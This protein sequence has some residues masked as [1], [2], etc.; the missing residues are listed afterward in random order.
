MDKI[1]GQKIENYQVLSILGKGGM[2]IVYKA[3]DV[4]LDRHV[5]I[6]ILNAQMTDKLRFIER[7]KREAKN[8]A[9]LSHP[10]I[11]T[12]YGFI[13]Y[14]GL[15]GI[16]MEYVEGESLEKVIRRQKR[17]NL[18]DAIFIG[19]QL[20]NAIEY[21]HSKGFIHRDI[22]PSN[23]IFNKEGVAKIMDFGISKSMFDKGMTKTGSK[24][25]TVFY[26][27]PEQVRGKDVD[28]LSDIY[29]IGCTLYEMIVGEPPFY[30]DNDYDIMDGHLKQEPPKMSSKIAG[31]PDIID[32]ILRKALKKD[33]ADRYKDCDEFRVELHKLDKY[34]STVPTFNAMG[35][36]EDKKKVK[37]Y[38]II[39]FGTFI[40]VMFALT[41]F[42]YGQVKELLTGNNLE[43]FQTYSIESLFSSTD[44]D[45]SF[46]K[47]TPINLNTSFGFN[48]ITFAENGNGFVIGDSGACFISID[49]GES[50]SQYDSLPKHSY[51]DL[52]IRKDGNSFL[53]GSSSEFYYCENYLDNMHSMK[54]GGDY[55]L[56]K[57][58]FQ[59]SLTGFIVGSKG[60][61]L[62]TIDGGSNWKKMMN[63][64]Q[65][66][67]FDIAFVNDSRGYIVGWNGVV[68]VTN[69]KGENWQ[70]VPQFSKKY[71][72]SID[73]NNENG[74]IVGANGSIYLT[75]D[76]GES[77][78]SVK[79]P[80]KTPLHKV[81]FLSKSHAIILGG[82]GTILI[83]EDT[84]ETW[85][86]VNH[87]NYVQLNDLALTPTG[88][89]VICG[90]NGTLLK[91]D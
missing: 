66:L 4:K 18:F 81:H 68:M 55:S 61:I 53:V 11:V 88:K 48:S 47:I 60:L 12:V 71:L 5:A 23:I 15:L 40:A 67:L 80:I 43:Q 9:K 57:I 42:V 35:K 56:F 10:N 69:D 49:N 58:K 64:T 46:D 28:H 14:N 73:F 65:N 27:S 50:W 75:N 45:L 22:K 16:V 37:I 36:K 13:E 89:L 7:F 24:V 51:Y 84:G 52:D 3:Y 17:L 25:G 19:T 54:L 31:T 62:K 76:S 29:S 1:I 90:S 26:M 83:S 33:P 39:G 79:T 77:W 6:K 82:K 70:I 21:A 38:S 85:K 41:W 86:G 20:L 34:L 32:E 44:L 63:N 91:I 74:L 2:G 72:K 8:Q 30:S 59:D 87:G 78:S